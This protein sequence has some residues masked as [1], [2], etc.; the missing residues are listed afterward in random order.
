MYKFMYQ[1]LSPSD[2][3]FCTYTFPSEDGYTSITSITSDVIVSLVTVTKGSNDAL[4]P[5]VAILPIHRSLKASPLEPGGF[6]GVCNSWTW[7]CVN[8]AWTSWTFS[9]P[10]S[11][12]KSERWPMYQ[13]WS[14]RLLWDQGLSWDHRWTWTHPFPMKIRTS[15][16]QTAAIGRDFWERR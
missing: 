14:W 16:N 6:F 11:D 8:S 12:P 4:A 3:L 2:T 10:S 5:S 1:N 13:T 7:T 9:D 15:P